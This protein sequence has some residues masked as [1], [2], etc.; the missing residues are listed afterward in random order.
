MHVCVTIGYHKLDIAIDFS[1]IRL[2]RRIGRVLLVVDPP[3]TWPARLGLFR[4]VGV[5]ATVDGRFNRSIYGD[6]RSCMDLHGQ[7]S[8]S[9]NSLDMDAPM[10]EMHGG[11]Q[12]HV[13]TE[14]FLDLCWR[15]ADGS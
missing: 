9:S 4:S 13:T 14:L 3:W 5:C 12:R 8:R 10:S 6:R 11:D 1:I 2:I 7:G 15:V